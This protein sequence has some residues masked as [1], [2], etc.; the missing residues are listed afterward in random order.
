MEGKI[1]LLSIKI[2]QTIDKDARNVVPNKFP[3]MG[4]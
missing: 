4:S 1:K 3:H 2:L